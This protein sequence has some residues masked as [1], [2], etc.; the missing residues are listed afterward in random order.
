MGDSLHRTQGGE[1]KIERIYL[2]IGSN[3]R[4]I[5]NEAGMTQQTLPRQV[6]MTRA[7]IANIEAGNQRLMLHDVARFCKALGVHQ[8]YI[9]PEGWL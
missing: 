5:R 9:L 1:M 3:I 6:E 8:R 4:A 7:S 2:A